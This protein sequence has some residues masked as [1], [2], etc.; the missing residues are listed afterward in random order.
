MPKTYALYL[1]GE[2]IAMTTN[3]EKGEC[4]IRRFGDAVSVIED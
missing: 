4:W 3:A 1:R 2:L